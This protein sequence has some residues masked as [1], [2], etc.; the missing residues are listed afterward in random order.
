MLRFL[1]QLDLCSLPDDSRAE[2]DAGLTNDE[3]QRA[4]FQL[5]GC[6]APAIDG[7]PIEFCTAFLPKLIIP[8]INMLC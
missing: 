4:V 7:F 2:L 3:I 8:L 5:T 1:E 6:K